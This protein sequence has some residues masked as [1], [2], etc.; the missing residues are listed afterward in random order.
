VSRVWLPP[1]F[2]GIDP[3][4]SVSQRYRAMHESHDE[5]DALPRSS[6]L[7]HPLM[8]ALHPSVSEH[9]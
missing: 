7:P 5:E 9:R 1:T 3:E 6:P 2:E 4:H 8:D